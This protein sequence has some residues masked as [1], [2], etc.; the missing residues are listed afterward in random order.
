[1]QQSNHIPIKLASLSPPHPNP[2]NEVSVIEPSGHH[3]RSQ[4][5]T[6]T[7]SSLHQDHVDHGASPPST[8]S[9]TQSCGGPKLIKNYSC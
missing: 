7:T 2:V 4:S 6:S 9:V 1:M 5:P 3:V 8:K